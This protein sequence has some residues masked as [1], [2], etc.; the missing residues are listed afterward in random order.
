MRRITVFDRVSADGYFAGPDGNLD[1]VV[2]DDEVDKEAAQEID[3]SAAGGSQGV[4]TVLFGRRTYEMFAAFWPKVLKESSAPDPHVPGRR[5]KEM[6]AMATWLNESEKVVFSKTLK[7]AT[8]NNT[9]IVRELDPRGVEAMKREPGKDMIIFGSGSIV[10]V[11]T[12]HG[13]IDEYRLIV[14]PVILGGGRS[15]ISGVSKGRKLDL[16]EAK[17]YPSGNVMLRYA[18]AA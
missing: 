16:M 3:K 14:G 9:R 15:L 2:P 17:P 11:L 4:G 7:E 18:G 12:E 8:W 1:W 5:S 13:L 6:K 10:S